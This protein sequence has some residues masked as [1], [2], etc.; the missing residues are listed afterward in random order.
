MQ[1]R[2][3]T[4]PPLPQ[5]Q[6]DVMACAGM[7]GVA[8]CALQPIPARQPGSL[9]YR[10][11]AANAEHRPYSAEGRPHDPQRLPVSRPQ[12]P[13]MRAQGKVARR[14]RGERSS[15]S[16][17]AAPLHAARASHAAEWRCAHCFRAGGSASYRCCVRRTARETL[18]V[19]TR[20]RPSRSRVR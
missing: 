7:R 13:E 8:E 9:G 15:E 19:R 18:L 16:Q 17:I 20:A 1:K 14:N 11:L 3:G 4:E 10:H 5:L 6:A 12:D 2:L